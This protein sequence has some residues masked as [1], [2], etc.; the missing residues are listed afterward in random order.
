VGAK[1]AAEKAAEAALVAM[2]PTNPRI[3]G[4]IPPQSL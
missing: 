3:K 2:T 1:N 4:K